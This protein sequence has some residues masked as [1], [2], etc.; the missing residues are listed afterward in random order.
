MNG[1]NE[2]KKIIKISNFKTPQ[3]FWNTPEFI[4]K[5]NKTQIWFYVSRFFDA[6]GGIPKKLNGQKYVSFDQKNKDTLIFIRNFLIKEGFNPTNLTK[7]GK[8]WQFRITRK[9]ELK[10]FY[11]NLNSFHS[12]KKKRFLK[13][14]SN[15]S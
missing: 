7:T 12:E 13:L 8:I 4:K 2:I 6:E 9:K 3:F 14:I 10:K 15:I 5:G 1:K 11:I